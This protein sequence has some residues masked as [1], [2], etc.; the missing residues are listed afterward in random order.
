MGK[1]P[2]IDMDKLASTIL[3][4]EL[5]LDGKLN[6]TNGVLPM[7]IEAKELGIK[8]VI[9]P[10]ANANEASIISELDII[11]VASI[12]E[13]VQHLN[14]EKEIP[15]FI[16]ENFIFNENYRGVQCLK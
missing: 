10:K 14:R 8:T 15:K 11:P 5:S 12:E 7:C 3:I 9:L 4:G 1:T 6:R 13:V 2:E 16:I